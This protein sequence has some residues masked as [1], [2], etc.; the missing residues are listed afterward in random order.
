MAG[1]LIILNIVS[2]SRSLIKGGTTQEFA[3]LA[4]SKNMKDFFFSLAFWGFVEL[5]NPDS[6]TQSIFRVKCSATEP[7]GALVVHC[8]NVRQGT[9]LTAEQQTP[10]CV[11]HK[12]CE[13]PG[14]LKSVCTQVHTPP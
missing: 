1:V 7:G 12:V 13:F 3:T 9:L 6:S 10:T 14:F 4:A 11:T 8:G 2:F 5:F